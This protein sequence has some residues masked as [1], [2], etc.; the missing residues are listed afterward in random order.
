MLAPFEVISCGKQV[1]I[2]S[3][4]TLTGCFGYYYW[5]IQA[6]SGKFTVKLPSCFGH[7]THFNRRLKYTFFN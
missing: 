2:L 7:L 3:E 6:L 5:H 1:D 4:T